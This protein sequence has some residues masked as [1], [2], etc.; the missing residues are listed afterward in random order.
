M[1]HSFVLKNDGSLWATAQLLWSTEGQQ[2]KARQNSQVIDG[3]VKDVVAKNRHSVILKEDGSI[4]TTGLNYY[5]QLGD[6][7][8]LVKCFY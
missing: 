5:G 6:G 2:M 3:N 7:T 8:I 4:W 1:G